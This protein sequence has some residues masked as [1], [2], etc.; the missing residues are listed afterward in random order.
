MST[1]DPR[2]VDVI[3]A[4]NQCGKLQS[5]IDEIKKSAESAFSNY[6]NDKNIPLKDRWT[7]FVS[8]PEFHTHQR[9][10]L[11]G[12]SKAMKYIME[13]WFDA[14]EIYGRGKN[15]SIVDQIN[16]CDACY[17]FM[18][19]QDEIYLDGSTNDS[20][21]VTHAMEELLVK[22]IGSFNYDW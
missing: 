7:A 21:A 10:I 19:G 5:Q 12:K 11:E 1:T 2:L 9:W 4:S 16:E 22:R 18:E 3:N 15:I 13:N 6:I 8:Y 14:P 17:A 20:M